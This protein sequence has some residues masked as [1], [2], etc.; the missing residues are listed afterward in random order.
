M[1]F[2]DARMLCIGVGFKISGKR[3]T[4]VCYHPAGY[5]LGFI[6][7][8][9]AMTLPSVGLLWTQFV[10]FHLIKL[11]KMLI[12]YIDWLVVMV[13]CFCPHKGWLK[14]I[15]NNFLSKGKFKIQSSLNCT[16]SWLIHLYCN[17]CQLWAHSFSIHWSQIHVLSINQCTM[18]CQ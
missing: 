3:T 7:F 16:K 14:K 15:E 2:D 12:N 4:L 1:F 17:I 5:V 8:I 9:V 13:T 18:L 11:F 10:H 6:Y